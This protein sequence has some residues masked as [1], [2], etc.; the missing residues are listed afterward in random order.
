M[1]GY[2]PTDPV[3]R[4]AMQA[5]L[6]AQRIAL[7]RL[8]RR[9]EHVVHSALSIDGRWRGPASLAF[10]LA[11]GSIRHEAQRVVDAVNHAMRLTEAALY[12]LEHGV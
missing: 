3:S 1:P 8:V 2:P 7:S 11:L 9:L 5:D 6:E 12:E 4:S 10:C